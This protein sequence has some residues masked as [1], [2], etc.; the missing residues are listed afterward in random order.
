ML[1]SKLHCQKEFNSILFSYKIEDA[2]CPH[3][4]TKANRIKPVQLGLYDNEDVQSARSPRVG[5][6]DPSARRSISS[7]QDSGFR[8]QGLG[9]RVQG[10]GFRVR[11]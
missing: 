8:V 6:G 11:V 10:S 4:A 3:E 9:F 7:V 5:R 1:C 2:R